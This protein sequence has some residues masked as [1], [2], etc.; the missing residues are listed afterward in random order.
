MLFLF[1][2]FFFYSRAEA[3]N[4]E[5]LQETLRAANVARMVVGHTIQPDLVVTDGC[6]GKVYRIDV[7]MSAGCYNGEPSVI[8][9]TNDRD[10]RVLDAQVVAED[11]RRYSGVTGWFRR[12]F[13]Q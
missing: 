6:D 5:L 11:A 4:C 1:F 3:T 7:G 9:I 12:A 10:V 13:R 8:E 2:F